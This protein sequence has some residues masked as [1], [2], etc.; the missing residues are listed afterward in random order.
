MINEST[1]VITT[2]QL[3]IRL[4]ESGDLPAILKFN[5]D[6]E[7]VRY[8]NAPPWRD[9][10]DAYDW[11]QR[12]RARQDSGSALQFVILKANSNA[13]IGTCVL[14]KID[15]ES[16]R[17][18]IGYSLGHEHWGC[19]YMH[20]ALSA[21]LHYAFDSLGLNRLE[22]EIDSRNIRSAKALTRLGFQREGLLRERWIL[23]DEACDSELFGLLRREWLMRLGE[24]I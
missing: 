23:N 12:I 3:L 20:E 8:R 10:S 24:T 13:V 17:A 19:G 5:S 14:F 22:A 4:V 7:M 21:L 16:R 18:E 11:L 15:A 1:H 2:D 6:P 9:M